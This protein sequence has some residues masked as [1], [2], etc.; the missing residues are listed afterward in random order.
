MDRKLHGGN[1][2]DLVKPIDDLPEKTLARLEREEEEPPLVVLDP[3]DG[4][5]RK[6]KRRPG[7]IKP[8]HEA[9]ENKENVRVHFYTLEIH[10]TPKD[11]GV[12]W[13][14]GK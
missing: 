6:L 9:G 11:G 8:T 1:D 12:T 10:D 13:R 7:N 5:D 14:S 2:K 3:D 4:N